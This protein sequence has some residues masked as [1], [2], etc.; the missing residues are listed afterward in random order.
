M[1][2]FFE[3]LVGTTNT[4]DDAE[5]SQ[6]LENDGRRTVLQMGPS[7]PTMAALTNL[8]GAWAF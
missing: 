1:G 3:T 2:K 4:S 6:L 7:E 8:L 5:F